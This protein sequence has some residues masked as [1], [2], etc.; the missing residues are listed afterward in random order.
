MSPHI[1]TKENKAHKQS[2]KKTISQTD[3]NEKFLLNEISILEET[4]SVALPNFLPRS[5]FLSLLQYKVKRVSNIPVNFVAEVWDY[6][7]TVVVNIMMHHCDNYPPLQSSTKRAVLN[8]ISKMKEQSTS[9]VM[10]IIEMEEIADK[11]K[12]K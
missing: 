12:F 6:N 11:H 5:A 3:P 4:K 8:L 2:P 1:Y 10:E 7:E 9:R